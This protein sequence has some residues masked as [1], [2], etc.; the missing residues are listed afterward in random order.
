MTGRG[1]RGV[2]LR[3]TARG[4]ALVAAV[5]VVANLARIPHVLALHPAEPDWAITLAFLLACADLLAIAVRRSRPVAALAVATAAPLATTALPVRPA[6]IGLGILF[7]AYTVAARMP[8]PRAATVLGAAATAHL[9][10]GLAAVAG[11]GSV[12]GLAAFWGGPPR[13]AWTMATGVTAAYL[14][15]AVAGLTVRTRRVHRAEA[16]A[17][18]ERDREERAAAAV[19]EER[20]RI[21]R[22]L[23]DIAA[24]DLSAIVVQAGAAD[25]LLDRDPEAVRA[26]LRSIRAQG[27]DTLTALRTMVGLIREHE[28]ADRRTDGLPA[29]Q[30]VPARLEEVVRRSRDTGLAVEFRTTGEPRRLPVTVELAVSRLVQEALANAGEHAPGAPVTV[31]AEFGDAALRVTV[32]NA[33]P[34]RVPGPPGPAA[35]DPGRGHGLLGM[36]ERVQHAGGELR[37]GPR[38]GGGWEVTATFPAERAGTR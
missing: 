12:D 6:L 15:P 32:R 23:H 33:E 5:L 24:H 13:D 26:T 30:P 34:D 21:A 16:A 29:P 28:R 20:A 8:W 36:R 3:W 4:D 18:I 35:A 1:V 9:A 11:G 14:L 7:C 38:P 17:R 2:A 10:G 37:T 27:R 31:A 22:E 19:A 25:R